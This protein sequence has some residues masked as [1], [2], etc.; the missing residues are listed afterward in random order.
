[1][2][3][4][5]ASLSFVFSVDTQN[6]GPFKAGTCGVRMV[7][8]VVTGGSICPLM[9]AHVVWVPTRFAASSLPLSIATREVA[10]G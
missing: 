9:L 2:G 5:T 7:T 10:L 4:V 8:C 1:M 6:G 3:F